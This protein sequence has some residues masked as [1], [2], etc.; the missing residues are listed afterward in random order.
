MAERFNSLEEFY[1]EF[2]N[3]K[4]RKTGNIKQLVEDG[5][6]KQKKKKSVPKPPKMPTNAGF[7]FGKKLPEPETLAETNNL[8]PSM[9]AKTNS[10]KIVLPFP[11]GTN[12]LF[13]TFIDWKNRKQRRVPSKRYVLW[14]K[15][16]EKVLLKTK[17][18][19][20]RGQIGIRFKIYRPRR[21]GDWDGFVKA[22]QDFLQGWFYIDDNQIIDARVLRYD[23]A[24]NPRVEIEIWEIY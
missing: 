6:R 18:M 8:L 7:S 3:M 12:N 2:P 16:A 24:E 21:S 20:L 1:A 14:R 13:D 22:P 9:L 4:A 5:K 15:E 10:I 19:I 11:P 17:K 23:D